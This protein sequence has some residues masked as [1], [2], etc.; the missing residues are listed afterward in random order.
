[1]VFEV[2]KEEICT[3]KRD[4]NSCPDDETSAEVD[5][6]EE[7][8]GND[9]TP[10]IDGLFFYGDGG[11]I[12]EGGEIGEDGENEEGRKACDEVPEGDFGDDVLLAPD[13]EDGV[14]LNSEVL[15]EDYP[16]TSI[17]NED[18]VPEVLFGREATN[19]FVEEGCGENGD[20]N[21][22]S[23]GREEGANCS[24][25]D[26]DEVLWDGFVFFYRS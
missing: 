15:I 19:P 1:M 9:D 2:R 10:K 21:D 25:E 26:V 16:A 17:A 6:N 14:V 4:G 12:F 18:E 23:E 20:E 5:R 22:K 13:A 24:E 11:A 8:E 3:N 7:H